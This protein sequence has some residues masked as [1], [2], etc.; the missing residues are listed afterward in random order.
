MTALR[1]WLHSKWS[2][3]IAVGLCCSFGPFAL[4]QNLNDRPCEESLK[5]TVQIQLLDV[6]FDRS[7]A[8]SGLTN[9]E[10]ETLRENSLGLIDI[11][12]FLK[13]R[14]KEEGYLLGLSHPQVFHDTISYLTGLMAWDK[15]YEAHGIALGER[16]HTEKFMEA[17]TSS[18][19]EVIFLIPSNIWTHPKGTYTKR[20]LWW[21]L[22]HPDQLKNV[23]FVFGSVEIVSSES[24][25]TF[26]NSTK[27][28]SRRQGESKSLS[29]IRIELFGEALLHYSTQ[30]RDHL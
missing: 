13:V 15:A 2:L 27:I 14:N 4:G 16:Q 7:L 10:I 18:G 17:I 3:G 24:W 19:K 12:E 23:K 6:D 20:E 26:L 29:E 22:K 25:D 21:L 1:S 9:V 30:Y 5:S 28:M 11:Y 8:K